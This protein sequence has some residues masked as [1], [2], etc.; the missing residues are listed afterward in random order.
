MCMCVYMDE[1]ARIVHSW[2]RACLPEE[3]MGVSSP[4][5]PSRAS[6]ATTAQTGTSVCV[7]LGWLQIGSGTTNPGDKDRW[8][9]KC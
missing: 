6:D 5:F 8:L 4:H 9:G 3:H 2:A 1:S 7:D